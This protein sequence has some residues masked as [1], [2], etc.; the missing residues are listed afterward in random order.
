MPSRRAFLAGAGVLVAV[1]VGLGVE[2]PAIRRRV[3]EA[4]APDPARPSAS[5]G[6]ATSGVLASRAMGRDVSWRLARPPGSDAGAAVPVALVLHGRGGDADSAF[7]DLWFD[8]Y[9]AA[10]VRAGAPPFA[11]ASVDGG[12]DSYWHRRR[13]GTDAQAML[14]DE[15]LPL[16]A[17]QG[18]A[19][20][21]FGLIGW[22]MGGYGS[23][24]LAEKLGAG[25]VAAVAADSPALWRR[26]ADSASG[27]FDDAADFAAHDVFAGRPRLAGIPVRIACGESDPFYPA[28]QQFLPGV[29]TLAGT[30]FRAGGH[31]AALW[32]ST[33]EGQLRFLATALHGA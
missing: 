24:L 10:V 32:R 14:T 19:T 25:R 4:L 1:G 5:P 9:L 28:V 31:T 12:D 16:L 27:A 7:D 2:E 20:E 11:L 26:F 33:A 6:P 13:D 8:R 30:D 21:R 15:F 22:S 3:A 23:L 18:L 29:P 17:R